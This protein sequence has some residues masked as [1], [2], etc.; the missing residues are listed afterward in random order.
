VVLGFLADTLDFIV[1]AFAD[2]AFTGL[3]FA[4]LERV[5]LTFNDFTFVVFV[6][7]LAFLA[8]FASQP[9]FVSHPLVDRGLNSF[10]LLA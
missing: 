3:R 8:I 1:L 2:F 5:G 7:A 4:A 10:S 9:L 6:F